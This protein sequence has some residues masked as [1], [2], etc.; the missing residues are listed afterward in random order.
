MFTPCHWTIPKFYPINAIM[1]ITK[2]EDRSAHI[3]PALEIIPDQWYVV[4]EANDLRDKPLAIRRFG[5]DLVLF[6]TASGAIHCFVDR[7]PHRGVALSLGQVSGEELMCGYHGFRFR[8]DGTCSLMPCEGPDARIPKAMRAISF[9]VREAH[10]LLWVFWGAPT[11]ELPQIPWI[12]DL[13]SDTRH[14]SDLSVVWPVPTFR[15]IQANFDSHHAAFL[16]GPR[17]LFFTPTRKLVRAENIRCEASEKSIEFH[18]VMREE[19]PGGQR[20]PVHVSFRL[21]GV[22]YVRLGRFGLLGILD[23]PID[24]T[25]TFRVIRNVSPFGRAGGLGKLFAQATILLDYYYGSQAMEDLPFVRTQAAPSDLFSDTFVPADT[26][27]VHYEQ[28]RQKLMRAA[29]VHVDR[30]PMPVRRQLGIS[31]SGS[32]ATVDAG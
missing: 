6:R 1:H 15:A 2:K 14:A 29:R 24:A 30:Y 17:S 22:S 27:T 9:P 5:E 11:K 28:L 7:C 26:G 21:P 3:P 23:T 19:T 10:G 32:V 18:I 31:G 8:G 12:D 16:H 13:P 4:L 20:L 25:N